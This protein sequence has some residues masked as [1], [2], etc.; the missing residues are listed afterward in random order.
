MEVTSVS[1]SYSGVQTLS[2]LRMSKSVE[3]ADFGLKVGL[4]K[5]TKEKEKINPATVQGYSYIPEI[6]DDSGKEKT[7]EKI[8]IKDGICTETEQ[9]LRYV[10]K[11]YRQKWEVDYSGMSGG[12]IVQ[13]VIDRYN[14][15]FDCDD[16][17]KTVNNI[18]ER[19]A[20]E[21]R[22]YAVATEI[23]NRILQ[24]LDYHFEKY[25]L[26]FTTSMN[27]YYGYSDM[28]AEEKRNDII[29]EFSDN[30][31]ITYENYMSMILKMAWV[32]L[33]ST[34]EWLSATRVDSLDN[35]NW[36]FDLEMDFNNLLDRAKEIRDRD[37]SDSG[38]DED[39]IQSIIER[40]SA[41][42]RLFEYIIDFFEKEKV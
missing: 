37:Y 16:I 10:D 27:E 29:S 39:F 4:E 24:E 5:E 31:K 21:A 19:S 8:S 3:N 36:D 9:G 25:N 26:K 34:Q 41:R 6:I 20:R 22:K 23:S 35:C 32:E 2:A 11:L 12:E 40:E 1:K 33:L 30:G 7:I 17:L 42:V 13:A 18:F 15:Y 28:T 14:E 38:M